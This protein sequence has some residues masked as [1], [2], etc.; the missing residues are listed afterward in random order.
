MFLPTYGGYHLEFYLHCDVVS[1]SLFQGRKGH[2]HSVSADGEDVEEGGAGEEGADLKQGASKQG[3]KSVKAPPSGGGGEHGDDVGGGV[4]VCCCVV[5]LS[6][7]FSRCPLES[8]LCTRA[9]TPSSTAWGPS[10]TPPPTCACG[11]WDWPISVRLTACIYIYLC[12]CV[13]VWGVVC[14]CVCG[15]SYVCGGCMYVCVMRV[16]VS[17]PAELA[18]VLWGMVLNRAITQAAGGSGIGF[19]AVFA[20]WAFWAGMVLP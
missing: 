9:S 2:T 1:W 20:L 14:V 12:V 19:V 16:Y 11:P 3:A 10:P 5:S 18:E 7:A 8:C 17:P 6:S 13:C 15:V 4:H